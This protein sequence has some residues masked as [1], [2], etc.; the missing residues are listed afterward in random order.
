MAYSTNSIDN[1]TV[2]NYAQS[3]VVTD[4]SLEEAVQ[5]SVAAPMV[6]TETQSDL[7]NQELATQSLNG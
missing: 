5:T 4:V 6:E 1:S 3:E 7:S 2:P